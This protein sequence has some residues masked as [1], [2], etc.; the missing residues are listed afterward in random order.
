MVS[1]EIKRNM[2]RFYGLKRIAAVVLAL[3]ATRVAAGDTLKLALG[4]A[5]A[6]AFAR[7]PAMT[8]VRTG[9]VSSATT[10]AR[11][12]AG[13]LPTAAGSVGYFSGDSNAPWT[14]TLTVNQVVFSPTALLGLATAAARAGS[15]GL[16]AREQ[17]ARL[18]YD[19]TAG[20]LD[21][22]RTEKLRDVAAAGLERA[23]AYL[24]LVTEQHRLGIVP[25]VELLRAQVRQSEARIAL[26]AAENALAAAAESFK[27]VVGLGR[28]VT[29]Q[30][31]DSLTQPSD[32][33]V[34]DPDSLV[35]AIERRNPSARMAART[36]T[37]AG[38]GAA[39]AL[40]ALLPDVSLGWQSIYRGRSLPAG[41]A[42]WQNNAVERSGLSVTLPLPDIKSYV[43]NAVDAVNSARSARAARRAAELQTRAAAV[44]AVNS[45][46]EARARY[47]L[48]TAG[49]ELSERLR[50]LAA[51][52][53]RLGSISRVD[54]LGVEA[55]LT[56][57]R[58]AW[59]NAIC[60]TYQR[61]A[62]VAYLL[63]VTETK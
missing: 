15:L 17:Q 52:Q 18:V 24:Q 35:A 21:L 45:Y 63:G 47:E 6:L 30:A 50:E 41:R 60:D 19:V 49:L 34:N 2:K 53:L 46:L 55:E 10:L 54:F 44:T 7:S 11:G 13:L 40:G 25:T 12:I 36:Q 43:L 39:A 62:R 28:Q 32:F 31:T 57:A 48:A 26:L 37:A 59:V 61:A 22:L 8:E 5:L 42:E 33:A 3:V 29:V 27:A 1:A 4:D 38:L 51:E 23:D 9:R 56:S 20:Y 58:S 16:G 14:A